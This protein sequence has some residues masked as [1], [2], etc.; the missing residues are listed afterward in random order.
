MTKKTKKND[1]DE[2]RKVV[3]VSEFSNV[4]GIPETTVRRFLERGELKGTKIGRRWLIP[5]KELE[6]VTDPE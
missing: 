5:M 2:K 4:T 6:R 3:N 1:F